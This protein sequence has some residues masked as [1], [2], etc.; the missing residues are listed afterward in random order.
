MASLLFITPNWPLEQRIYKLRTL[1]GLLFVFTQLS[2]IYQ[3]NWS[4]FWALILGG[5]LFLSLNYLGTAQRWRFLPSLNLLLDPTLTV[6]VLSV[7]GGADGPYVFLIYLHV[8]SAVV[9]LR[10]VRIVIGIGVI[11]VAILFLSSLFILVGGDNPNWS[12]VIIHSLGLMIIASSLTEPAKGLYQDAETDPL[13]GVL[14]RRSGMRELRQWLASAQPLN[15]VFADL[16]K[17][18]RINDT[19]GHTTG[20]AVLRTV[21]QRILETIRL[22]D[23]VVRYGGD[24]FLIITKGDARPLTVRLKEALDRPILTSDGEVYVAIDFGISRYPE[25]A[26][27]IDELLHFADQ[28]MFEGK[29]HA[30]LI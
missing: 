29:A 2:G 6:A 7:S 23:F 24:E 17:F 1:M 25:D 27:T 11:Q 28:H 8:L 19:Y 15:L 18:K 14:N 4:A 20:D 13:T 16:K 26:T 12:Y 10:D 22:D 9:F 21:A 5:A 3:I 30:H